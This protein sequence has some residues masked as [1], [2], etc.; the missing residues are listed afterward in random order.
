[1]RDYISKKGI[2]MVGYDLIITEERK[3]HLKRH[4]QGSELKTS[5][6]FF[7]RYFP[8]PDIL[9]DYAIR[10]IEEEYSGK[11]IQKVVVHKDNIGF[12]SV[13]H[14]N[15]LP[16]GVEIETVDLEGFDVNIVRGVKK[17]PTKIMTIVAR[18]LDNGRH[19]IWTVYPGRPSP[20]L[21]DR[22]YWD[23]HVFIIED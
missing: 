3:N 5:S 21:T 12:E 2:F 18:P 4:L 6:V 22:G 15:E 9:A 20:D 16:E 10:L 1:M 17:K 7:D 8:D 23:Q 14:I 11:P 13:C 19:G